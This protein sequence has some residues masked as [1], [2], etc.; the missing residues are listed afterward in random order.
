[1]RLRDACD[2]RL[3]EVREDLGSDRVEASHFGSACRKACIGP[4]HILE[5]AE[6]MKVKVLIDTDDDCLALWEVRV[7]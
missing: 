7:M 1:M 2:A 5:G 3:I 4:L 6:E